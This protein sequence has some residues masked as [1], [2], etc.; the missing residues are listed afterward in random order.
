[1]ENFDVK[2][3][4][5]LSFC[6]SVEDISCGFSYSTK[7]VGLV[8]VVDVVVS[9]AVIDVAGIGRKVVNR[10]VAAGVTGED[11]VIGRYPAALIE[12]SA[13]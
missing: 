6:C 11:I 7:R 4:A 5:V 3:E 2:E 12:Y 9:D 13:A 10:T 8:V 1:M